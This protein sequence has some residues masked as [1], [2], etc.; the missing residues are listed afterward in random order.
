MSSSFLRDLLSNPILKCDK[1]LELPISTEHLKILLDLFRD[2]TCKHL[3]TRTVSQI[4]DLLQFCDQFD[5]TTSTIHIKNS[6]LLLA[7]TSPWETFCLAERLSDMR[8]ATKS[9]KYMY[10]EPKFGNRPMS[11]LT[12]D[13]F[14]DC[15]HVYMTA[16]LVVR[17]KTGNEYLR[18]VKSWQEIASAFPLVCRSESFS[19]PVFFVNEESLIVKVCS[20]A[21]FESVLFIVSLHENLSLHISPFLRHIWELGEEDCTVS[22]RRHAAYIVSFPL[23]LS[24]SSP[25]LEI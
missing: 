8:L 1:P 3:A 6:L 15:P 2:G 23:T 4:N 20:D 9:L 12:K 21:H 22:S 24:S 7:E 18:D 17:A 5:I 13:R 10:K 16:L 14:N 19:S 25:F 11:H